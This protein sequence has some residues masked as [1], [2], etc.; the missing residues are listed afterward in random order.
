VSLV[1]ETRSQSNIGQ[2]ALGRYELAGR[3]F[4]AQS[5]LVFA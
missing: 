5:S 1:S 2:G 3:L 4:H